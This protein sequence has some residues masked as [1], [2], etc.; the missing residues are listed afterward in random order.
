MNMEEDPFDSEESPDV[1]A[2]CNGCTPL[3]F[4]PL[5]QLVEQ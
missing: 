2:K 5:A 4:A 3:I 1:G